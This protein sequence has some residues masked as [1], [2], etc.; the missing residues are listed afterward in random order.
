VTLTPTY[1]AEVAPLAECPILSMAVT[2]HDVGG[3][4]HR[5][6]TMAHTVLDDLR[7]TDGQ[8]LRIDFPHVVSA[9]NLTFTDLDTDPGGSSDALH[10][11]TDESLA[12]FCGRRTRP[13]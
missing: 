4:G 10:V 13:R 9:L 1:S 5:G 3:L 8:S 7:V 6:L 11:T 12:L 2:T